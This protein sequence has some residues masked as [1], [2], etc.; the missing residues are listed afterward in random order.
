MKISDGTKKILNDPKKIEYRD[1]W[2]ARLQQVFS[3]NEYEKV[4][5]IK[6]ISGRAD[7]NMLLYSNPEKWVIESLENLAEQ[8]EECGSDI[9][10]IPPCIEPGVY[11]VHFID[12]IFGSHVYYEKNVEQ[13]YND[14]INTEVGS[15]Q[16]PDLEKSEAWNMAT[17]AA[18]E[19]LR[20][21]VAL[22]L[23]GL[24]TIASSLV[25]AV[26]L[27]GE[28]ILTEMLDEPT[29][30]IHDFSVINNTLAEIHCWYRAILPENQLQPVVAHERTQPPGYGQICGC[31]SQLISAKTYETQISALDNELLGVYPKGGMMHL[32]GTHE[33]LIPSLRSMEN[34]KAIQVNDRAAH[35]LKLYFEGL[36][37]DQIIYLNP[38]QGMS[39]EKA[40]EI[41]GGRR[42]VIIDRL[43]T[44]L[45]MR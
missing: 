9:Q 27:Y 14:S 8:I 31:T 32:C 38:C 43:N 4:M 25:V 22:P 29:N 44:P 1:R 37:D 5:T 3:G 28:S 39:I 6:G 21:E 12:S 18:R 17:R 13:W 15:L 30:A 35:D 45:A 2:F 20:Q 26:N 11:G 16:F 36:R 24:P 42:L 40:M 19:F 41:T 10:F 23:F 34:L 33:H 7:D